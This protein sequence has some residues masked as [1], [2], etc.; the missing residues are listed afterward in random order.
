MNH[1]DSTVLAKT[2]EMEAKQRIT[3]SLAQTDE[4]SLVDLLLILWRGKFIIAVCTVLAVIGGVYYAMTA[5]EVFSTSVYFIT[6]TGKG[7]SGGSL[8]QLAALAGVSLGNSGNID[9]SD[10]LDKVI[11]DREFIASLYSKKWIFNGDS[12][13]LED[14]LK[15]EKDTTISNWQYAYHM[16]QVETIRKN[17][18]LKINKD[19]KT[20]VL[21]LITHMPDPQLAYDINQYT[22]GFLSEYI[23][24]SIQTQAKEKRVFIEERLKEVKIDLRNSENT[25]TRFKERNLMSRSPQVMLEEAR[26]TRQVTLNQEIYIQFQK[27]FEMAK[28]EELDDQ[29][30]IQVI[31]GAEVP[32]QRSK[33][34]KKVL[35]IFSFIVG[36]V[37]GCGGAITF[38]LLPRFKSAIDACNA[39]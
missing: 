37:I 21:T 8:G 12:A 38:Y 17:N 1:T 39:K 33:P 4:I 26:L 11:Q 35:V 19:P 28:I 15:I 18:L 23:R 34:K 13:S 31:K 7:S 6:K 16:K 3:P 22:L 10:Y 2:T 36:L 27:Q 5:Q 14:I 29:T 30:L 24:N 20:G 32:I 25:L 9:P